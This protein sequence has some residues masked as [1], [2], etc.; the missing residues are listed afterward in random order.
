MSYGVVVP[1]TSDRFAA[2]LRLL[3]SMR[4]RVTDRDKFELLAVTN[5]DVEVDVFRG[6][7]NNFAPDVHVSVLSFSQIARLQRYNP[8]PEITTNIFGRGHH[9]TNYQS[10]KTL[11][12]VV[13][14]DCDQ[15]FVLSPESYVY[16]EMSIWDDVIN[17]YLEM[18]R[19]FSYVSSAG[20]LNELI[21][22]S[23]NLLGVNRDSLTAYNYEYQD[24]IFEKDLLKKF[25]EHITG[26]SGLNSYFEGIHATFFAQNTHAVFFEAMA[27]RYY[28]E[29]QAMRGDERLLNY[30][31]LDSFDALVQ[32]MPDSTLAAARPKEHPIERLCGWLRPATFAGLQSFVRT[33][34]LA[35][36]RLERNYSQPWLVKHFLEVTPEIKLLVGSLDYELYL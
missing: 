21:T 26:T 11:A 30:M 20:F 1:I 33:F 16:R 35:M 9:G 29:Q 22:G 36:L 17:T 18:P 23:A 2:T 24:I 25:L 15:V 14:L 12:A 31:F 7:L 10:L 8:L 6:M 4:D 27:Y 13:H 5:D 28:L 34:R 32:A 3:K 19:H